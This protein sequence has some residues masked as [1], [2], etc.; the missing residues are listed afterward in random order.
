MQVLVLEVDGARVGVPVERLR[1]ITHA[2]EVTALAAAPAVVEGVVDYHGELAAVIDLRRRLGHPSRAGFGDHFVFAQG[3]AR[4]VALRA[5]RALDVA[6]VAVEAV[7]PPGD[8]HLA[9]VARL[10]DGL[11][12]IGDLDTFLSAAEQTQLD[13]ALAAT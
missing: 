5:D 1:G 10:P 7:P 12:L 6:E 9:G 2:V 4:L 3:A 13:Q 8:P 11:L